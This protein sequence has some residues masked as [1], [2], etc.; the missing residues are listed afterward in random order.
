MHCTLLLAALFV[1]LSDGR[2]P[3]DPLV[4]EYCMLPFPNSYY[5]QVNGSTVTGF[6]V[7]FL[8]ETFPKDS[9]GKRARPTYWNTFGEEHRIRLSI[10]C[11]VS[12]N[13]HLCS[14][15]LPDHLHKN[16]S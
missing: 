16:V 1:V 7:N 6:E 12:F 4:P 14:L 5:L 2:H 8:S 11:N 15:T 10:A 3:C 9:F 13:T